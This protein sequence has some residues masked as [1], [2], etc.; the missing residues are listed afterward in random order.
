[1]E[2]HYD[3]TNIDRYKYIYIY[4][5][6]YIHI[7]TYTYIHIYIYTW[8]WWYCSLNLVCVIVIVI[9]FVTTTTI[10]IIIIIIIIIGI[11]IISIRGWQAWRCLNHREIA[12][13]G[14]PWDGPAT[15]SYPQSAST[16]HS[17]GYSDKHLWRSLPV[18]IVALT[19]AHV[20]WYGRWFLFW[21]TSP[22]FFTC[23]AFCLIWIIF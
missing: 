20:C 15:L 5:Y 12:K 8:K 16:E 1:M 22:L 9:V 13:D 19:T 21:I 6:A 4:V 17:D 3:K 11:I 2:T 18:C 14:F 10:T 23:D 7:Y